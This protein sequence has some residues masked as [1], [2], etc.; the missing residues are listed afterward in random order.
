MRRIAGIHLVVALVAFTTLLSGC[1]GGSPG[2]VTDVQVDTPDIDPSAVSIVCAIRTESGFASFGP[3]TTLTLTAASEP[4]SYSASPGLQFDI[5][6]TTTGVEQGQPVRL[7]FNGS[8]QSETTVSDNGDNTGNAL[9]INVTVPPGITTL[10]VDTEN[11]A[12]ETG[13]IESTT[14]TI[15][16]DQCGVLLE[17]SADACLRIDQ[18]ADAA[19]FQVAFT[20]TNVDG[21]CDNAML[22]YD[23]GAGELTTDSLPLD[24]QNAAT[25]MLTLS[26]E[27]LVE[28]MMVSVTAVISADGAPDR[29]GES[30][31][32]VY[33][34]DN[35]SP[36]VALDT[37]SGNSIPFYDDEDTTEPGLQ[38]TFGGTVTGLT[39]SDTDS[40]IVSIDGDEVTTLT[41]SDNGQW[42]TT[43][44]FTT[45]G[46]VEVQVTA[47]DGCTNTGT[48]THVLSVQVGPP[49]LQIITPSNG[50]T[51]WAKDDGDPNTDTDYESTFTVSAPGLATPTTL[52]VLCGK[53]ET[54]APEPSEVGSLE[55]TEASSDETYAVDVLLNVGANGVQQLCRVSDGA[56]IETVSEDVQI[57]VTLP[58]PNLTVLSP[59][60]GTATNQNQVSV[61]GA[62]AHLN[63]AAGTATLIRSDGSAVYENKPVSPPIL[64]DGFNWAVPL[65]DA[66]API[67]DDNYEIRLDAIDTLGNHAADQPNSVSTVKVALDTLTP[68][69]N[70]TEPATATMDPNSD[71]S[72]VAGF[73]TT[74]SALVS[75]GGNEATVEV[76]LTVNGEP[77]ACQTVGEGLTQVTFNDVTLQPG[78]NTL[79]VVGTDAAGNASSPVTISP[80]LISNAPRVFIT[81]PAA[82]LITALDVV[83]ISVLV[84][85]SDPTPTPISGAAVTLLIDEADSN[86]GNGTDMGNGV[87]TF[88][89]VGIPSSGLHTFQAMAVSGSDTG[90]SAPRN[91]TLKED[92]PSIAFVTPTANA[93]L[94][95]TSSACAPGNVNCNLT[96]ICSTKNVNNGAAATMSVDCGGGET[97]YNGI[98]INDQVVFSGAV[99][100]NNS[101]CT[102]SCDVK[103]LAGTPA[104]SGPITVTVD[105]TAPL[106]STFTKPG[107]SSLIFSN[108]EDQNTPGLQYS[109]ALSVT[110]I[111]S[112]QAVQIEVSGSG[113]ATFTVSANAS[114]SLPD[115][116]YGTINFPQATIPQGVVTL[117]ATTTDAAGKPATALSKQV[118]VTSDEPLVRITLPLYVAPTSCTDGANTCGA[119]AV[120][121][122]GQCAIAWNSNSPRTMQIIASGIPATAQN[123]RICTNSAA[124]AGGTACATSGFN[125]IAISTMSGTVETLFLNGLPD[126]THTLIAEAKVS[127]GN[128]ESSQNAPTVSDQNRQIVLDSVVPTVD[129]ISSPNDTVDPMGTLSEAEQVQTG[130]VFHVDVTSSKDGTATL[131]INGNDGPSQSVQAGIV[132]QFQVQL[133]EG[134]VSIHARVEDAVGNISASPPG[135]MVYA[136]IVDT[137]APTLSFEQPSGTST[138]LQGANL[139]VVLSSDATGQTVS[140]MD[141]GAEVGTAVVANDGSVSFDHATFGTLSDG[142]HVLTASVSDG[143]QNTTFAGPLVVAVDTTPPGLQLI[144]PS[145]SIQLVDADDAD[146]S[147][148]GFQLAVVVGT[149]GDAASWSAELA[150]NCDS[151]FGACNAAAPVISGLS[152]TV[153]NGTE[154][155][156]SIT[157]PVYKSPDYLVLT[158]TTKDAAGNVV[159]A[160]SNIQVT[161]SACSASLVGLPSTGYVNNSL[162]TTAGDDCASVSI[163]F[164]V[165]LVGA[166]GSVTSVDLMRNGLLSSSQPVTNG[167]AAFTETFTHNEVPVELEATTV[168][169]SSVSTGKSTF[170]V[171]LMDPTPTFTAKTFTD[172]TG[173]D[174]TSPSSGSSQLYNAD[175][176]RSSTQAGLQVHLRLDVTDD[177]LGNGSVSALDLT[178][179]SG[180][181]AITSTPAIPTALTGTSTGLDLLNASLSDGS[182]HTVTAT[183][184]DEAGNEASTSFTYTADIVAPDAVSIT[185]TVDNSRR[186]AV[187]LE[188]SAPSDNG[189][190]ATAATAY[191][192]RYSRSPITEANFQNACDATNLLTAAALPNPSTQGTLDSYTVTGPDARDPNVQ[193]NGQDCK[194]VVLPSS[195]D[196]HFAVRAGDALGN[197]GP[198]GTAS[199]NELAL[200]AA[201]FGVTGT[202]AS[203]NYDKRISTVGDINND[204]FADFVVGGNT[205]HGFCIFYGSNT[206]TVADTMVDPDTNPTGTNYQCIID[207]GSSYAGHEAQNIGDFNNDG[208][209]DFAVPAGKASK[210]IPNA[211]RIYLGANGG[212]VDTTPA[213]VITGFKES[214][215]GAKFSGGGDFN[216]DGVP[217]IIIGSRSSDDDK[218]FIVPGNGS[219]SAAAPVAVD[220]TSVTDRNTY[221]VVTVTMIGG[222]SVQFG[223]YQAFVGNILTDSGATQYDDVVIGAYG[224]SGGTAA[225]SRA[226]VIK[227]RASA[228]GETLI[229]VSYAHDGS[230]AEDNQSVLLMSDGGFNNFPSNGIT[231]SDLNGDGVPDILLEH[232]KNAGANQAV[233]YLFDGA[234]IANS[235]GATVQ[236]NASG[237]TA[238]GD[239]TYVA[240]DGSGVLWKGVYNVCSSLGNVDAGPT[241]NHPSVDFGCRN[242][243]S[244]GYGIAYIR[245]NT[246]NATAGLPAGTYPYVDIELSDPFNPSSATFG[247]VDVQGIGD[248]NGDGLTDIVVGNQTGGYA[249]LFY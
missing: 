21:S 11:Q 212:M 160:S 104:T 83:D 31:A 167:E 46:T 208:F 132:S 5:Q 187:T 94:N 110:G 64:N 217:D 224:A 114:S 47:V 209:Q 145:A 198:M 84:E 240:P 1:S 163:G 191:D 176:D 232:G 214:S 199:T 147:E 241:D 12:G 101:T 124:A 43:L 58:A 76:C 164:T 96:S 115:G 105:R 51:L 34:A 150:S 245:L 22:R 77:L 121:S 65:T 24:G 215:F 221:Q 6:C 93:T 62:A 118:A 146:P 197:W 50:G 149:T 78:S 202:L 39:S 184:R 169:G 100:T 183:V 88:T 231:G 140:L 142:N 92:E 181:T 143:A 69:V 174:F 188:W 201:K 70:I 60:T 123:L 109:M 99:L 9:F 137:A 171:D 117:K 82:D 86:V 218:S 49:V 8:L 120:C 20:V 74:V 32:I 148:G 72:T 127:D 248:F 90:Y 54:G 59:E 179:D 29:T 44:T 63:G 242:H 26:N 153:P 7:H 122:S 45:T 52:R 16:S 130:G 144:Q 73:Q 48:T 192:V 236:L 111:E 156:Q 182:N 223:A 194:F 108:D 151:N 80:T 38:A 17:P 66:G 40:I 152:I 57:S 71:T 129:N 161:L 203:T 226:L 234:N 103:D 159:T 79:S 87:Y 206:A 205:S 175:S 239:E 162:C 195:G 116:T 25:F 19:G 178:D 228:S 216:G 42:Q 75:D 139:D 170:K 10:D 97:T 27:D 213:M 89:G 41:P 67:A 23:L 35:T 134:A 158:V 227:G 225:D 190:A 98:V 246:E 193:E 18:D 204:G 36:T 107:T 229:D 14:L 165:S 166:C 91:I 185:A 56:T 68:T 230:Q 247:N 113:F 244:V 4:S 28:N 154:P 135:T 30:A 136:P 119:G 172:P 243:Y 61:S 3:P 180:T 125:Q 211:V 235:V 233:L 138:L 249:V 141:N 85:T 106:F 238:Q 112:G 196:Y 55:V 222:G 131:V 220:L 189:N 37:P 128:W 207:S 219:V 157:L 95:K 177:G 168:G 173:P 102:L 186:P 53:N 200:R 13:G 126:G 15:E 2:A 33:T 133:P 155:V 237:E 81:Q 210:G